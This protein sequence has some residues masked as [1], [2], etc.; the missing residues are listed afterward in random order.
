MNI[1]EKCIYYNPVQEGYYLVIRIY[2][3]MIYGRR[4]NFVHTSNLEDWVNQDGPGVV[5]KIDDILICRDYI[6]N[7]YLEEE[8]L[9]K[10]ELVK[11]LTDEEFNIIHSLIA[12]RYKWPDTIIDL[13]KP[14][15]KL[16]KA[17]IDGINS[18]KLEVEKLNAEIRNLEH[19]LYNLMK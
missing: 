12:S 5:F 15:D 7:Y 17:I 18:R 9:D 16:V 6:R 2:D 8:C 13:N 4:G 14:R 1:K 3:K 11:E 10:F 19:G